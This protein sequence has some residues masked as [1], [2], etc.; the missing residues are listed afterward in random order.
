MQFITV[1]QHNRDEDEVIIHFLQWNGNQEEIKKLQKLIT[2]TWD[3][4]TPFGTDYSDFECDIEHIISETAV[5]EM[6]TLNYGFESSVFQKH[7]GIF[8]APKFANDPNIYN[9]ED[10]VFNKGYAETAREI[11]HK[12]YHVN[13]FEDW[14]Y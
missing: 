10:G 5:D 3:A 9:H 13:Q 6:I 7:T 1:K 11:L 2:F 14:F 12:R 8:R 4:D